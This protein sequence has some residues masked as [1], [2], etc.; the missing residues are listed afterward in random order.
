MSAFAYRAGLLHAENV[1]LAVLA[2]NVG[3]P[4]YVYSTAQLKTN[5]KAFA[6]AFTGLNPLVCYAVKANTNQAII[7]ILAECGAGADVTS[8]GELERALAAGI[9]PE[10]IIYS[11]VGKRCDEIMAALLAGVHQLNVESIPELRLIAEVAAGLEKTAPVAI[12]VNPDVAARTYKQT[13]TGELSTKFGIGMQQLGEAMKLA[14]GPG[15]AFRGFQVHI[16][17]HVHDYEPFRDTF[18]R[19][20]SLVEEWRAK[21]VKIGHLDLGGGVGIPYDGQTLAPFSEYAAIVRKTLGGLGCAL[22]FEPG[23]RLVGD[24]GI[25]VSRVIYDK[26]GIGKRFLILDAGMNDLVRPAMYGARHSIIPVRE[27]A[28]AAEP[29]DVVGPVCETGDLFGED[30]RL[31]GVGAGDLIAILQAGAYG[32]VMAST[33]NGR[34]L[35]PE[36]LVNG[37]D[38]AV[39][40]RRIPITEQMSWEALPP[41][42]KAV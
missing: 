31:P 28:A 8:A 42:T 40:R 6:D 27:S 19:L 9:R 17:S 15:M 4:F 13:S 29:A 24:A 5:Y 3:T 25:L 16:G 1:A 36:V 26:P 41:W 34:A 2:E 30:Y 7:R 32:S 12:R 22:S 23:R 18:T 38:Y 11:G 14:T 39:I 37:G 20:A 10:K 35:V 21:G 33:Y